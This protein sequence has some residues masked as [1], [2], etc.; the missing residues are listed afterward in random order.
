MPERNAEMNPL[1]SYLNDASLFISKCGEVSETQLKTFLSQHVADLEKLIETQGL[2]AVEKHIQVITKGLRQASKKA[3]A[4]RYYQ[5]G[6]F[7]RQQE[8]QVQKNKKA[9][10]VS[11]KVILVS[12]KHYSDIL[13]YLFEHGCSQQKDIAKA[14]SIDKSNLNRIMTNLAEY[15]LVIKLVGPKC[16]FFELS[17]SGYMFVREQ[18]LVGETVKTRQTASPLENEVER[19]KKEYA[20][21][22]SIK[23][24]STGF[25]PNKKLGNIEINTPSKQLIEEINIP[26]AEGMQG[27]EKGQER[28]NIKN[29]F[30][31]IPRIN[32]RL[33]KKS[34]YWTK[35]TL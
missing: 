31:Y 1:G 30:W 14:L 28:S 5:Y 23:I 10:E 7:I 25:L 27:S 8:E 19:F 21:G 16:A 2:E 15:E 12:K 13:K 34:P 9:A 18:K 20:E 26:C 11:Q 33:N 35:A 24:S 6:Y 17:S 29:V 32:T 4:L 3:E 22:Q